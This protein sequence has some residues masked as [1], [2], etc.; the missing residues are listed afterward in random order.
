MAARRKSASDGDRRV[1]VVTGE[2]ARQADTAL[3]G[4]AKSHGGTFIARL[5]RHPGPGGWHFAPVPDECAPPVAHAW[6]RTPVRATV[7]GHTWKT[8]VWRDTKTQRTLLAFPAACSWH[9]GRRR[10][11]LRP[12]RVQS[13]AR[14]N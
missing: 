3:L 13:L 6:G 4:M 10:F 7:D 2:A 5:F 14:W 8:R 9:E 1:A 12:P 11:R